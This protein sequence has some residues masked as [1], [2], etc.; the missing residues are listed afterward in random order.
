MAILHSGRREASHEVSGSF[1]GPHIL[2]AVRKRFHEQPCS[3][4]KRLSIEFCEG[5]LTLRGTVPTY[6][7]KQVAQSVASQVEGVR[8]INNQTRVV[9]E[10]SKL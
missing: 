10:N 2:E 5:T 3:S 6:Y 9:S 8:K 1:C 4:L 7:Q